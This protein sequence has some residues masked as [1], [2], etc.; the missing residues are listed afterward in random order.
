MPI[1]TTN[2]S[3]NQTPIYFTSMAGIS[4]HYG[5]ISYRAIYSA[6]ATGFRVYI[7]PLFAWNATD[8]LTYAASYQWDVNW[9]GTVY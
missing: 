6:T 2:C 9:F 3:F 1:D 5:L 8:M 7:R 4:S